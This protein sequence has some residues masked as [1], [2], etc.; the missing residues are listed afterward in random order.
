MSV[1][2]GS[3]DF[4]T[5]KFHAPIA[6][7]AFSRPGYGEIFPHGKNEGTGAPSSATETSSRVQRHRRSSR[8]PPDGGSGCGSRFRAFR[9]AF[10]GAGTV[11]PGT[12]TLRA[13]A[14][15]LL[16]RRIS[17]PSSRKIEANARTI[18][19]RPVQSPSSLGRQRVCHARGRLPRASRSRTCEVRKR[20]P[21]LPRYQHASRSAP[22]GQGEGLYSFQ[23][24]LSIYIILNCAEN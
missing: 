16:P 17:E 9:S 10:S 22:R 23:L 18:F 13:K 11:L 7:N 1:K 4:Q 5:A 12:R 8:A 21:P 19:L 14:R 3:L 24:D 15:M 6:R 20:A 2:T